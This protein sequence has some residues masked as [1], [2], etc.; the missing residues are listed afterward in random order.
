MFWLYLY[1]SDYSKCPPVARNA[2]MKAFVP[3][4]NGIINNASQRIYHTLHQIIHHNILIIHH[5]S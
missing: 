2:C 4:I 5:K 3:L 1:H